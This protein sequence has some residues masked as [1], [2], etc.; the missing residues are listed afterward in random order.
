MNI[1]L[2]IGFVFL[3]GL[4]S[5]RLV[6]RIKTPSVTA[7]LLLG[8]ILGPSFTNLAPRELILSSGFI[9]H[10]VLGLIA[11]GLGQGFTKRFFLELGRGV[12]W[13]S[14]LEAVFPWILVSFTLL[15]F[16][17]LPFYLTL[18]FGAISAATAPAATVMVV[19]EYKAKG[20]FTDILLGVV[21]IDDAWC[22][23][24]F[25][26]SLAISKAIALH[27]PNAFIFRTFLGALTEIFGAFIL[28]GL[29][30]FLI[31]FFSKYLRT[32][33]EL[34][35][36]TLGAV[37]LNTGLALQFH[38]SVLLANMF[39]GAVLVNLNKESFKFF[40]I[41]KNIDSP[42][43]LLFF[44]LAGVNLEI[45]LLTKIGIIG[46]IYIVFRIIGKVLGSFLGGYIVKADPQIK[47]YLGLG[48]L[49]QAGV[50]L[51]CA[52][53]A[54]ENFPQVGGMLFSVIVA[55]TIVY[56]LIGPLCTRLALK[57]AGEISD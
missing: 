23:I 52:L 38:L 40:E 37:L 48:L 16:T 33:T 29:I 56:E 49:P 43:Y 46:I 28:G 44:V 54:K 15:I 26:L 20:K 55:T 1:I 50:A 36:Y 17:R 35:I 7:Y 8:I 10:V 27:T 39:L 31:T 22:L 34:L 3:V 32:Q 57:K 19:R 18:L 2:S 12:L 14:I 30:A 53:I 5:A 25:A 11:F 47:K 4:V 6:N 41:L 45:N 13:I 24:V 9:S 21:A 42:L 51:G